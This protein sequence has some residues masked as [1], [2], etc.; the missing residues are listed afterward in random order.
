MEKYRSVGLLVFALLLAGVAGY[1]SMSY[2]E[3]RERAIAQEFEENADYVK[4][5]VPNF[6]LNVGDTISAETVSLRPI[7]SAYL[8]D[9]A[10]YSSDFDVVA[11]LAVSEPV[12]AGRPLMRTQLQGMAGISSFSQLLKDGQRAITLELDALD[13]NENML[14]PGDYIDIQMLM[15]GDDKTIT[16]TPI[17]DRV[18]VLA[19]GILTVA[20]PAYLADQMEGYA[21]VTLGISTKDV[22]KVVAAKE[23]GQLVYL[24]RNPKDEGKGRYESQL[25]ESKSQLVSIYSGGKNDS[26]MLVGTRYGITEDRSNNWT[27]DKQESRAYKKYKSLIS[28][29]E[30]TVEVASADTDVEGK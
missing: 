21:T 30:L 1:I 23:V 7:P 16:L 22:N 13:S 3:E 12:S 5:I 27:D 28:T 2:L 20:D 9:G 25:P 17:L 10:L 6:D 14:M 15:K 19:T 11:G 18:M 8:S 29:H 24:L 4:V 26:G